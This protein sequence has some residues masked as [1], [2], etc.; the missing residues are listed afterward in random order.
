MTRTVILGGR[1]IRYELQ[2]KK[3]KNVNLRIRADGS[4]S[5]SASRGVPEEKIEEF[6][7]EKAGVRSTVLKR[8]EKRC[9]R[10]RGMRRESASLFSGKA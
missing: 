3:V 8:N 9:P 7:L 10:P 5:V 6:L 2:R 1:K 4:V